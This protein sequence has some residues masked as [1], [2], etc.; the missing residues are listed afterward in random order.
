M[1]DLLVGRRRWLCGCLAGGMW[2]GGGWF[3]GSSAVVAAAARVATEIA[4]ICGA[5]CGLVM[6]S[7]AMFSI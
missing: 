2:S 5:S 1:G 3:L 4:V 6:L 7:D